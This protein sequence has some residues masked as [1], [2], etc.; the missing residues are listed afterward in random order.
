MTG[1]VKGHPA[2]SEMSLIQPS[3]D[4]MELAESPINLTLR[5][6]NSGSCFASEASSVVQTG[7]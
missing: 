6:V 7:V 5:L 3:C 4:S 1:K 2:I